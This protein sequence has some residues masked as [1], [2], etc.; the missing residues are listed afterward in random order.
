MFYGL[1]P[2]INHDDNDDDDK[3]AEQLGPRFVYFNINS[4]DKQ[5]KCHDAVS[6]QQSSQL[7]C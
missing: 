3:T 4:A 6:C 1:M 7:A 5:V 2:E